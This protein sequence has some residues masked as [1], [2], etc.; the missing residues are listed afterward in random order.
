MPATG[1]AAGS[2][3]ALSGLLGEVLKT[4]SVNR[5]IA[6]MV[7]EVVGQWAG[8]NPLKKIAARIVG[9]IVARGFTKSAGSKDARDLSSLLGDPEFVRRLG[10]DLPALLDG[11]SGAAVSLARGVEALSPGEKCSFIGGLLAVPAQT[12]SGSVLTSLARIVNEVHAHNPQ[13]FAQTMRPAFVAFLERTDFGEL[14]EL[15]DNSAADIVETVR[16]INHELWEYPAKTVCILGMIPSLVNIAVDSLRETLAPDKQ[17][18]AR[19]PVRCRPRAR[20][21][22]RRPELRG[23]HQ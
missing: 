23:R 11:A 21:R 3:T 18:G 15:V 6:S 14:K 8:K 5:L 10:R 16:M 1:V 9:R 22:D 17:A 20:A 13:Y 12:G 19:P 2:G 4:S 7:P